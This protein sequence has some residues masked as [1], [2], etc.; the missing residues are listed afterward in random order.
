MGGATGGTASR[1]AAGG[2]AL[3]LAAVRRALGTSA[4][5]AFAEAAR[6]GAMCARVGPAA[7]AAPK[8]TLANGSANSCNQGM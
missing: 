6:L 7:H 3:L 4:D 8:T 1:S 2:A 5:A